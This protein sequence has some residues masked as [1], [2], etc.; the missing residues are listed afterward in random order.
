MG[1]SSV[2]MAETTIYVT[3]VTESPA[4][5]FPS[6]GAAMDTCAEARPVMMGIPPRGMDVMAVVCV[7]AET[8]PSILEKLATMATQTQ[9]MGVTRR[10]NRSPAAMAPWN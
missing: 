2:M 5:P 1:V 6:K 3:V 10:A 4:L 7:S 8:A 9:E